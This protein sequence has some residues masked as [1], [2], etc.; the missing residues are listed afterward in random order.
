[1]L[2]EK[3][4]YA[5]TI[6]LYEDIHRYTKGVKRRKTTVQLGVIHIQEGYQL[7]Q[8]QEKEATIQFGVPQQAIKHNDI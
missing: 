5:L 6:G 8:I 3:K 1:M 2:I 7:I 4:N